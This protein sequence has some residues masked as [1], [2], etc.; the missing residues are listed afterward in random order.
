M[1]TIRITK[2]I[3]RKEHYCNACL[4]LFADRCFRN[5]GFSFSEYREIVK[6]YRDGGKILPGEQYEEAVVKYEGEVSTIRQ[7]PA[8]NT[9]AF[10]HG[11]Y[12]D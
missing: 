10:L 6:A 2:R 4:W 5:G 1:E 11:Y 8:I 9:I 7:K 3:A 12:D